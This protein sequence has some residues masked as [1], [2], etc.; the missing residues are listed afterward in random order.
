MVMFMEYTYKTKGTCSV[1]I[2]FDLKDDKVYNIK[3]FRK[4]R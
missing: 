3:F 4:A 2:K 1:Q